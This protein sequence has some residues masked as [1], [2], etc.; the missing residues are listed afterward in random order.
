MFSHLIIL[1]VHVTLHHAGTSATL[2]ALRQTYWIPAARHYIKSILRHCV[3][4]NRVLGKPYSS[5]DPP[6]LPYL[7]TQDVHPFTFTGVDFTGALYVRHGEQE[8]KVYL[9]LF[10]CATT[11]AVHL[12]I[13]QDLTAETFLLAFRKFAGRRS[14]P[15]IMISDNGST[16]MS[17]AE[18]LRKLMELTEVKEELGRRGLSW[19]FIPKRAPWYGGFWERFVGLTKTAIKKVLGRRHVSLP[20][21]ETIVVEIEAILN[22]RPLTYVSSE[23]MDP[24]PLTPS[25]LLH[26]RRI[27]CLPHQSVEIDE[28]TDP[29]F[30]D[31]S[32]I[33]KRANVRAAILRDFQ[34]RWRHEYLTS[35]RD[36]HRTSG[37]NIQSV[38]KG[39][40]VIVHD[41]TPRM[42]WKLA[43]IKDLIV[44]RDG[45]T[46]AAMIRTA[47]G[48]TSRSISR[49]YPLEL[50]SE[51]DVKEVN[52][53]S[54][55]PNSDPMSEG[56]P[57]SRAAARRAADK[58]KEWA[59]ILVAPPEDVAK[60][61]L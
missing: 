2:T 23:L 19:Q 46:R 21:L 35:L 15:K 12:E 3:I 29:T 4:C 55:T 7:W 47:N 37:N 57:P 38:K 28:L 30:G 17:A 16:Y 20:T 6:P 24:D 25:H 56:R 59:R 44:G 34:T 45:L 40:V 22:D 53:N 36:Y 41:D 61:E 54:G 8:V 51:Q 5:P 42:T 31:A 18:E 32:R 9:C 11:R 39:D 52:E 33:R 27:T 13:V 1:N 26:G 60:A 10:T 49:L 50:T 48:T 43:V 14:L 58:V